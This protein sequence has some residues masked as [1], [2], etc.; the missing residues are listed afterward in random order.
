MTDYKAIHGKNILH[1]ASDLDNAEGEGQIWFNTTS[2][3]YKTIVKVAGTWATGGTLTT[4][5][6]HLN[7]C[8]TQTAGLA[9]G[10]YIT[11]TSALSEEYNGST[12]TEGNDLNTARHYVGMSGTQTAGLVSGGS[13]GNKNESEEYNGTSWAEGSNLNAVK[14]NTIGAGIQTSGMAIGG[15][16]SNLTAVEVYDGTSWAETTD[17]STGRHNLAAAGS[18]GVAA[19]AYGGNTGSVSNATEE[20]TS[21]ATIQTVAFD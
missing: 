15:N 18:Q 2:S 8:G 4:G 19:I 20:W 7:S 6:R 1:V 13:P 5:R 9:A 10:G 3:D 14:S 11:A 21:T 16:P 17:L 12:W